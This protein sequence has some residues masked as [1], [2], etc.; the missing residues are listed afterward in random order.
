MPPDLSPILSDIQ[1][2]SRL[3]GRALRPYQLEPARAV[4]RSVLGREGKIITV[5]FGRQMGKNETSAQIE[6]HLLSLFAATGGSIVKAAPSFKPQLITSILRLKDTLDRSPVTR[7]RWLPQYGYM[8]R[9]GNAT[10]SFLSADPAANVVGATASLLLEIDE[11]QDV[12]PEKYDRDFRPMASSTNATTV[13]YGTAWSED[14]LLE[15][16]RRINLSHEART[17]ERLHFEYDWSVLAAINPHYKAFVEGEIARL[18]VEHPTIRTQYLLQTLSDAGRLFSAEQRAALRGSHRRLR[19][20]EPDRVYVAGIDL[21]GA[22]EQAE[23]A[24]ARLLSP[25][26][27][28][29]VITIAEVSRDVLGRAEAR[30]VDHVWWTGRDQVWQYERLLDLWQRWRLTRVAVDAS[31]I[32]AG[33]AA[34]LSA[35]HAARTDSIVFSAPAKSKLAYAMLTMINARRLTV[36]ADDGSPESRQLWTEVV[37]C[38][39]WLRAGEQIGWAV[40]ETEGHDDFV[41]SLALCAHAAEQLVIPAAGTLIRARPDEESRW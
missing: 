27:D 28:S 6:A 29:T 20:P 35:R 22:D 41:V 11:A 3:G 5:M 38:R 39:Y 33:I 4:V 23:D 7:G 30:V 14:S 2:F 37:A 32:G 21:A 24:V 17:G 18:G 15:R 25:R 31:G 36:Y 19:V 12:A 16:Q 34:F 26:R 13:L 1:T 8:V 10:I 9:L 40:P